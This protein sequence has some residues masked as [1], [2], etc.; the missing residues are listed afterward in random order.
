MALGTKNRLQQ[1]ANECRQHLRASHGDQRELVE[2][3]IV[4]VEGPEHAADATR[5]NQFTDVKHSRGE[6][7]ERV[8]AAF[9]KWLNG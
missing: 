8:E 5:W 9:Q 2:E 3:F 1:T 6:M 4:E 7:L